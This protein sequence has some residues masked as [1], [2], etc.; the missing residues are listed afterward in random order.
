[1]T[2]PVKNVLITGAY[3]G[4]G[5]AFAKYYLAKNNNV[6][7]LGRNRHKLQDLAGE[8]QNDNQYDNKIYVECCDLSDTDSIQPATDRIKEDFG[9]VDILINC[10]GI[11]PVNELQG[12]SLSEFRECINVNL[13][14]PFILIREF[15]KEM[16]EGKW[17][18]IINIASSSAYGGGPKTS[19]YCASKH[20]LLGLSRSLYKELKS[21]NVRVFCVSPGSIQ[22]DMGRDVEKLGQVYDTFM[23]AQ[24]VAE[25]VYYV[26]SFDGHMVSEEIRLNRLFVQ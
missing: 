26:T 10:A 6:C 25:Y 5:K 14:A 8:L 3:G 11:F 24:E 18:R 9:N 13:I 15:S 20:A 2:R 23:T 7:L 21:D 22:T 1:M 19:T 12:T 17:G 4:L 16:R